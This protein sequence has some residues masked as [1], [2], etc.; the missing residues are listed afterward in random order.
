MRAIVE[1]LLRDL[2]QTLSLAL[3]LLLALGLYLVI[4]QK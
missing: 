1:M 3:V 4:G 2:G